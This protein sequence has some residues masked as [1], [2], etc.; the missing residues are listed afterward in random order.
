MVEY[1]GAGVGNPARGSNLRGESHVRNRNGAAALTA[2]L[3]LQLER[4]GQRRNGFASGFVAHSQ[5]GVVG[6]GDQE[7]GVGQW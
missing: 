7:C 6:P 5:I 4:L 3:V 1:I 2:S